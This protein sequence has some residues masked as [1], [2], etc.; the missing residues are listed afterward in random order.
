MNP[1]LI[2]ASLGKSGGFM[3]SVG[4]QSPRSCSISKSATVAP[5]RCPGTRRPEAAGRI[6]T[7][8]PK[9]FPP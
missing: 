8:A 1:A 6:C 4:T 7:V 2:S 9:V 3:V 5:T